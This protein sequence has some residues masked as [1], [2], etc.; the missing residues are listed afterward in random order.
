MAGPGPGGQ[1]DWSRHVATPAEEY[2]VTIAESSDTESVN[3]DI[4]YIL[5]KD[6]NNIA[7]KG[8]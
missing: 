2:K 1:E 6:F 4:T 3:C 8:L 5:Y 7:I